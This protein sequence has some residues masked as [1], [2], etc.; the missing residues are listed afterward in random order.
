MSTEIKYDQ[1]NE[2]KLTE[3]SR[4]QM[5]NLS[6]SSELGLSGCHSKLNKEKSIKSMNGNNKLLDKFK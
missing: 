2:V 3:T 5:E 4:D 6:K 1:T